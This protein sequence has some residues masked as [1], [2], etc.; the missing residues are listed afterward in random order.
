[1]ENKT[2]PVLKIDGHS[3]CKLEIV[4]YKNRFIVKKQAGQ[5]SYN[6]RLKKQMHKQEFFYKRT[7]KISKFLT[8]PIIE[9][10]YFKELGFFWFSMDYLTGDSATEYFSKINVH[11]LKIISNNYVEYFKTLINESKIG[12]APLND[13]HDKITELAYKF[14]NN[15]RL[16][17]DFKEKLLNFLINSIPKE[18]IYLGKCHGDFSLTNQLFD[19]DHIFILDFL[20]SFLDSPI[21]DIVKLRQDSKIKRIFELDTK[22]KKYKY[23][24]ANLSITYLDNIIEDFIKSDKILKKWYPYLQVLNL[25]RI[26]PYTNSKKELVFLEKKILKI[27]KI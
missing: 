13:I 10:G 16:T 5:I 12:D 14:K 1:M 23:T 11:G 19:K 20:D 22:L 25:A 15:N 17:I 6:T 24:R 9:Q 21:I 7:K 4:N 2:K 18:R 27:I 3:G 8:A 26:I